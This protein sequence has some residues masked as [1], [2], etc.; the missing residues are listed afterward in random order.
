MR[1]CHG[2]SLMGAHPF[3]L[4]VLSGYLVDVCVGIV[5]RLLQDIL[6]VFAWLDACN[7]RP[8]D[9]LLPAVSRFKC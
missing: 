2:F 7:R 8:G 4:S 3:V 1:G 9:E 6:A 5:D